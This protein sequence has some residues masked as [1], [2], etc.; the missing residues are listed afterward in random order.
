MG[1]DK[2]KHWYTDHGPRIIILMAGNGRIRND[3]E[4][5]RERKMGIRLKNIQ[6]WLNIA[7]NHYSSLGF[8]TA[9]F[10]TLGHS[11]PQFI[12]QAL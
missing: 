8:S 9:C 6:I 11:R 10:S 3:Q 2:Q 12:V 5:E 4:R 1:R 7:S